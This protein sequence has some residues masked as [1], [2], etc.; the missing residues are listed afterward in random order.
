MYHV[1]THCLVKSHRD[2]LYYE[3]K[4]FVVRAQ[5]EGKGVGRGARGEGREEGGREGGRGEKRREG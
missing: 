5:E 2:F 4:K 1:A 3:Q